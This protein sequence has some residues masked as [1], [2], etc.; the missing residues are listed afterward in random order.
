MKK[1]FIIL[2]L[3]LTMTA[4]AQTKVT[5]HGKVFIE[6]R[7]TTFHNNGTPTEYTYKANDGKQ[8]PIYLSKNGKAY[9]V[10]TSKKT[11]KQYKQYLPQVTE[12]LNKR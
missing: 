6:R 4:G 2:L 8:Y 11:G 10:R 5:Q 12:Q 7:D 3:S 9:I 1:L